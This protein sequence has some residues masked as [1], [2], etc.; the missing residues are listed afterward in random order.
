MVLFENRCIINSNYLLY[1]YFKVHK[2]TFVYITFFK[3]VD[4][5]KVKKQILRACSEKIMIGLTEEEIFSSC[6]GF[7]KGTIK[8]ALK[9]LLKKNE[10]FFQEDGRYKLRG[11]SVATSSANDH[12][13]KRGKKRTLDE[14][15]SNSIDNACLASSKISANSK[16]GFDVRYILAPMVGASELPFRLLCRKYGATVAYTPMISS[17]KFATDADYRKKEFQTVPWD[18]PLVCH[19]SAN[20]PKE[21]AQAAKYV[22]GQCDAVDLNLGCKLQFTLIRS[23]FA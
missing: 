16:L 11:D 4:K 10:D 15:A 2:V 22:E 9:R 1:Q 13:G 14:S 21:F 17:Q 18:R 6:K 12:E 23:E 3:M 5:K 20:D 8:K 19:F 7:D